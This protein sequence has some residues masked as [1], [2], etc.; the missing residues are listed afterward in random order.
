MPNKLVTYPALLVLPRSGTF[1][2]ELL[3]IVS[4]LY[5]PPAV[6]APFGE[7][8]SIGY[9]NTT[10]GVSRYFP[11]AL[12]RL[13]SGDYTTQSFE[14]MDSTAW[15]TNTSSAVGWSGR[16]RIDRVG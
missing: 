12:Q 6:L 14:Q 4:V 15:A 9:L 10:F 7:Q 16:T 2:L 1:R 8:A 3:D 11:R 13:G 5:P